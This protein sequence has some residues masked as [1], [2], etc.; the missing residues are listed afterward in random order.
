[1]EDQ[2]LGVKI[3]LKWL[4]RLG[5]CG[6]DTSDLGWGQLAVSYEQGSETFASVKC[7]KFLYSLTEY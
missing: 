6:M 2:S 3:I 1:L 5:R 4:N 7:E